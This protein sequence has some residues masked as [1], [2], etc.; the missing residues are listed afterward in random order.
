MPSPRDRVQEEKRV[1]GFVRRRLC[2]FREEL[3]T[4]AIGGAL[5][6]FSML[7]GPEA[8]SMANA[9]AP[10]IAARSPSRGLSR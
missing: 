3:Q 4:A 8:W 9:L 10:V 1:F 2:A 6:M 5:I 7:S